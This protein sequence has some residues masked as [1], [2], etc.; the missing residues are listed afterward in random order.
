MTVAPRARIARAA[1]REPRK[2]ALAR[3]R[4]PG[5]QHPVVCADRFRDLRQ[6]LSA[7]QVHRAR[8]RVAGP[9]EEGT[10]PPVQFGKVSPR[11]GI[12]NQQ[13]MPALQLSAKVCRAHTARP[14][15]P[16]LCDAG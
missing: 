10:A 9:V 6:Q 8:Q 7:R 5:H 16:G 3:S 14:R 11:P 13:H 12:C 4:P 15:T 2:Y 1:S